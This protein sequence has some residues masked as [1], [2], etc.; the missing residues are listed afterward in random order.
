MP[1]KSRKT[2]S[3]LKPVSSL[4]AYATEFNFLEFCVVGEDNQISGD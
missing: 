3:E 1:P 2:K 4:N